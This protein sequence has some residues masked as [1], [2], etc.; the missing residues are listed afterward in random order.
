MLT[1]FNTYLR[2]RSES[3]F[4]IKQFKTTHFVFKAQRS[5]KEELDL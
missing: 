2:I 1:K 5:T 4:K 3:G